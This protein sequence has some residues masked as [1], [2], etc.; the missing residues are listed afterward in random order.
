MRLSK[1]AEYGLRAVVAM[2]RLGQASPVQIHDLSRHA[3]VPVKFLEHIL[4]DLKRAGLLKSKRGVGGGYLLNRAVQDISLLS[5]VQ[6]IDGEFKPVS[7]SQAASPGH[8]GCG[9]PTPC[10][11]GLIFE[12]L[13]RTVSK[14]LQ[15]HTIAD[16]LAREEASQPLFEI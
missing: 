7:C 3:R 4:L 8:C 2:G 14:F 9:Q 16:V 6:A 1:K 11:I 13:Q 15:E 12:D 10:G 5:V